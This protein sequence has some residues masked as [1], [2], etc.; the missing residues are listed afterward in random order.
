[1]SRYRLKGT[2]GPVINQV[3]ELGE[4]LALG[5]QPDCDVRLEGAG[6]ARA[7][8]VVGDD[9]Q[10]RLQVF[11]EPVL[12]NGKDSP[13]QDLKSGDELRLGRNAFLVQAPGLRPERVLDEASASPGRSR[14][15]WI[16]VGVLAVLGLAGLVAWQRGWLAI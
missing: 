9:G 10:V 5:A 1:M 12:V 2:A 16:A 11:G 14:A 6:D 8:L 13:G 4:R 3:F 15:V 7:E